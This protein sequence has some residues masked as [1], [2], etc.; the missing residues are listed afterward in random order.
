MVLNA[1][2]TIVASEMPLARVAVLKISAGIIQ[3]IVPDAQKQKLNTHV[4][5]T[6]NAQWADVLVDSGG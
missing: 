1:N 6:M 2:E 4:L 3:L 5:Q